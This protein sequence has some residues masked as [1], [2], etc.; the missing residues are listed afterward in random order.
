MSQDNSTCFCCIR[1]P[2]PIQ[3]T[4]IINYVKTT[5][6]VNS[7]SVLNYRNMM[8]HLES[9]H[10]DVI[11]CIYSSRIARMSVYIKKKKNRCLMN[12]LVFVICIPV[13]TSHPFPLPTL[14]RFHTFN[15]SAGGNGSDGVGAS[16]RERLREEGSLNKSL[17]N[18]TSTQVP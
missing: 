5:T 6:Y 1:N 11:V 3:A 17:T 13:Y 9:K 2:F 16:V 18:H 15:T 10:I 12:N 4:W 14:F 8:I 7:H